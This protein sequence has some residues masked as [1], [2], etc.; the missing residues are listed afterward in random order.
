VT[1]PEQLRTDICAEAHRWLRTPWQHRQRLQGVGVDCAQ[2]LLAVYEAVGLLQAGQVDP[3][4]YPMDWHLHRDEE[5]FLAG[6]LSV[7]HPVADPQPGDAA[8][9]K[10]GRTASHAAIVLS[11]GVVLHAYA[12]DGCVTISDL[13]VSAHLAER[14]VGYYSL[15]TP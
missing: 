10:F 3:G 14:L 11:P 7:A 6:V 4:E 1:S 5:R 8:I 9:F 13:T 12:P 2:L 15:I